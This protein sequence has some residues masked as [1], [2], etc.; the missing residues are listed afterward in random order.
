METKKYYLTKRNQVYKVLIS[1]K[2]YNGKPK[3]NLISLYTTKKGEAKTK[4]KQFLK[5]QKVK[6]SHLMLLTEE[7][8][9]L[10]NS[11]LDITLQMYYD[12]MENILQ[13][14]LTKGTAKIYR[15]AVQNFINIIGNKLLSKY[16]MFDVEEF[17]AQRIKSGTSPSTVNMDMST[18]KSLFNLAIQYEYLTKNIFAKTK[19]FKIMNK[20][21]QTFTSEEM[22]IIIN[23]PAKV[24]P[25]LIKCIYKFCRYS[26]LRITEILNIKWND[27]NYKENSIQITSHKIHRMFRIN[28]NNKLKEILNEL[29]KEQNEYIFHPYNGTSAPFL[30]RHLKRV[31]SKHPD[32]PQN[33]HIHNFRHT[34]ITQKIQAGVPIAIVQS[35]VNHSDI[36]TTLGYTHINLMNKEVI[37]YS[38]LF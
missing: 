23:E 18:L 26:G 24:N 2:K 34:F 27:I 21:I 9:K 25:V 6:Q 20:Q 19:K 8:D 36:K 22:D 7:D 16:T 28:I 33:L 11:P 4:F 29:V 37:D 35:F 10:S 32:I 17:K 30:N 1:S 14:N 12:K 13:C 38:N 5:E 31:I 15:L 3:Q